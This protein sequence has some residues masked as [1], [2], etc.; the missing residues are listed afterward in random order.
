[1]NASNTQVNR[2]EV[3]AR[4]L[5]HIEERL[6]RPVRGPVTLDSHL[7][8]DLA[9]DSM[10]A[11]QLLGDLEDHYGVTLPVQV[12]QRAKT[13]GE[14]ADGVTEALRRAREAG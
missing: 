12:L 11:M 5:A 8:R 14:V 2:D 3:A 10:E 13:L 1:M 6:G 4:L 9:L 7:S